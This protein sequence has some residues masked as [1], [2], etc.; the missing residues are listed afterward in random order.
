VHGH[1][2]NEFIDESLPALPSLL[3]LARWMP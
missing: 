2:A 1:V 3:Q